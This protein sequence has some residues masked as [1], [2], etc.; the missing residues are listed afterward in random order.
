METSGLPSFKVQT[1]I[2]YKATVWGGASPT[3]DERAIQ[4][5]IKLLP[6]GAIPVHKA[7]LNNNKGLKTGAF[8]VCAN[9]WS[10]DSTCRLG[11]HKTS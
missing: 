6:A 1:R 2:L 5:L 4:Q 9:R 3:V 10:Q 11:L 7:N 8:I